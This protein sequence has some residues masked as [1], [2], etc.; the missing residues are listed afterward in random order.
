[1]PCDTVKGETAA[2]I[3]STQRR[4]EVPCL[5]EVPEDG[6]TRN[7]R[8]LGTSAEGCS[9]RRAR[10]AAR[11]SRVGLETS[12]GF[13]SDEAVHELQLGQCGY[14]DYSTGPEQVQFG[15]DL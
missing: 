9:R 5:L 15:C 3:P 2:G 13:G 7:L 6:V 10:Q 1:M 14:S 12:V 8:D 11:L 4:S